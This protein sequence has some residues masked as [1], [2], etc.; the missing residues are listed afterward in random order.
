MK[1]ID[2]MLEDEFYEDSWLEQAYEDRVA[3]LDD[4]Y[5]YPHDLETGLDWE[6]L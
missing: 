5:E 2:K 6:E 4:L 3:Y 1:A